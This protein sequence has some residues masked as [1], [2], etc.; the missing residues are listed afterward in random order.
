MRRLVVLLVPALWAA[1]V[2]FAAGPDKK[3]GG[4]AGFKPLFDGTTLL[5]L[6]GLLFVRSLRMTRVVALP[7]PDARVSEARTVGAAGAHRRSHP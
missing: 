3:D 4:G 5:L 6:Y 1:G 7:A 2:V